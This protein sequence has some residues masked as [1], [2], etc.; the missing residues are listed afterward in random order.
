MI[1]RNL[2]PENLLIK[3]NGYLKLIGFELVKNIEGG[4]T[5]TMC[6]TPEYL[7]PEIILSKGYG[8][9]VDWWALGILLYEM[10]AGVDPFSDEDPMIVYQNILQRKLEF[11]SSFN[12]ES[13]SLIKHLLEPDLSKRYGNLVN[14]VNDI[15]N[16]AFFK[17][18]NWEKLMTEEILAPYIPKISGEGD[19]SN[20]NFYP[21][22][23]EDIPRVVEGDPF[24]DWDFVK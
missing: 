24:N 3:K 16:H 18:F 4:R 15:K 11:S 23:K 22:S 13:E 8:K 5:Y 14:G 12:Q 7:A 20:F 2:K 10:I 19:I 1:Y 21:D 9:P 17:T 6:G